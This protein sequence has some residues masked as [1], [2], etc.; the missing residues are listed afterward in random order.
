MDANEANEIIDCMPQGAMPFWYFR[1]RYALLLISM[2]GDSVSKQVIKASPYAQLLDK[3]AVRS[4]LAQFRGR[5]APSHAFELET[6]EEPVSYPLTLALWGGHSHW[7]VQTTRRGYSLVLQLNFPI[8]HNRT[9]RR[10]IDPEGQMP[11]VYT[12]HPVRIKRF[13]TMAWSRMDV[14][15]N[16]GEVLIEEIQSDW[17][18][19]W[20][21]YREV[22]RQ[23][24]RCVPVRGLCVAV[25]NIIQY[26]DTELSKHQHWPETMLAASIW[27]IRCQLGIRRIFY[28]THESGAA[29]KRT[30]DRKPPRSLYTKLPARFCFRETDARP[31]FMQRGVRTN[32]SKKAVAASRFQVLEL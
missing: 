14:D 16:N 20:R 27:F 2:L 31:A 18:R 23:R 15:L 5:A 22:A 6:R 24:R 17:M 30:G 3:A 9:Y 7:W 19:H 28:H 26:C 29:L 4:V 25:D 32:C 12:D 13:V 11:F 10:L 21:H 1:D 8:E